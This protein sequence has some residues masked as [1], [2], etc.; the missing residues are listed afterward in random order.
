MREATPCPIPRCT[1]EWNLALTMIA[2]AVFLAL[3]DQ[4][5]FSA[6]LGMRADAQH[7]WALVI[8]FPGLLQAT[9]LMTPKRILH[10]WAAFMAMLAS[11]GFA[12]ILWNGPYLTIL[13]GIFIVHTGFEAFVFLALRGARWNSSKNSSAGSLGNGCLA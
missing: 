4:H 13:T 7:L 8:G 5:S 10:R 3:S 12:V 6:E 2:V 1:L 11:A 9:A